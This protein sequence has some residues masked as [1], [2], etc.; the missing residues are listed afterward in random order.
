MFNFL[1]WLFWIVIAGI[2][3]HVAIGLIAYF[4]YE[5]PE[6]VKAKWNKWFPSKKQD[7]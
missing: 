7:E 3:L 2:Y 5:F 1:F 4:T 6:E